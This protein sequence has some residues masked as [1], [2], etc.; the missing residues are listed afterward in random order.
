[1]TIEHWMAFSTF[2]EQRF[3]V[4]PKVDTYHCILINGN[5]VAHAPDGLAAFLVEK[6]ASSAYVIDPQTHAFQHSPNHLKNSSG[7][8]RSSIAKL[9]EAYGD[10]VSEL[11]GK[12]PLEPSDFDRSEVLERFVGRALQF[13]LNLSEQ[14]ERNKSNEKYLG[15]SK[16]EFAP[17]FLVAPYFYLD[18][19]NYKDWLDVNSQCWH[20]ACEQY[21]TAYDIWAELVV[22]KGILE[23]PEAVANIGEAIESEKRISGILLWVD[24]FDEHAVSLSNLRKMVEFCEELKRSAGKRKV[25][26]IRGGFF[27]VIFASS[28]L[29][30]ILDGV[31]H[32]PEYGE[33]RAVVPVGGGIPTAKYYVPELHKRLRYR[34]ALDVFRRKDWLQSAEVFHREVCACQECKKVISGDAGNFV[35]FGEGT[36][37]E[38]R[39]GQG[40]VRMEFPDQSTKQK[41][42]K[43]YLEN[44][45]KEYKFVSKVGGGEIK[46]YLEDA[47]GRYK[48]ILGEEDIGH[49]RKWV[50]IIS[51][52]V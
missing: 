8:V 2:G 50:N 37:K 34:D 25:I 17:R 14:M 48:G 7:D 4:Y 33:A 18:E 24:E 44:K 35:K 6:T 22:S 16:D 10:P 40:F 12:R 27:S 31:C 52:R 19:T 9:A 5:M 26:N 1:M 41:C 23:E 43:H 36:A 3:F 39:R 47:L 20:A 46:K 32:G 15:S 28:A 21:G 51:E 42:L 11:A 49:L 45:A 29:G 30:A 13:Q 38:V